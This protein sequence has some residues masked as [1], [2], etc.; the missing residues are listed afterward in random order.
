MLETII[1]ILIICVMS[2]SVVGV[3]FMLYT[4]IRDDI[5]KQKELKDKK[6]I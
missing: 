1:R 5:R 3:S 2:L 4:S 6:E